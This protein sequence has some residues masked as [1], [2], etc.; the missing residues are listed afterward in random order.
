MIHV[1]FMVRL[2]RSD[3]AK[4]AIRLKRG[5]ETHLAR[6]VA[7]NHQQKKRAAASALNFNAKALVGLFINQCIGPRRANNVAIEPVGAF[8]SRVFDGIKKRPAIGRPNRARNA[9]HRFRINLPTP[10][11]F[12]VQRILPES[13]G[14]ERIGKQQ[15]VTA[16]VISAKPQKRMP[17]GQPIQ[18][19]KHFVQRP[20]RID[21]AAMNRI[22]LALFRAG[23]ILVA[24]QAIGHG[25]IRLQNA[26]KHFLIKRILKLFRRFQNRVGVR[27][28]RF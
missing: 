3:H 21:A 7:G 4:L 12:D 13:G 23:K 9:L 2:A 28:F 11:V 20:A 19:Q 14:V 10:Q 24:T 16:H 26:S 1:I 22:L 15:V 27:V 5:Q 18:I 25:Q 8:R 6:C 17:L